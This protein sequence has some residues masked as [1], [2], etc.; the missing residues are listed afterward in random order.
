MFVYLENAD[1]Q[2]FILVENVGRWVFTQQGPIGERAAFSSIEAED[3]AGA[4]ATA[5]LLVA[6]AGKGGFVCVDAGPAPR[7]LLVDGRNESFVWFQVK[8]TMLLEASGELSLLDQTAPRA[9]FTA[10]DDEVETLRADKISALQADGYH[11]TFFGLGPLTASA[12]PTKKKTKPRG[13]TLAPLPSALREAV[14]DDPD[15]AEH[16]AAIAD[17]VDEARPLVRHLVEA[18]RAGRPFDATA[19]EPAVATL[20]FGK[21]HPAIVY[22]MHNE[23]P[24]PPVWKATHVAACTLT[25]RGRRF[26]KKTYYDSEASHLGDIAA[27]PAFACLHA[28]DL[29]VDG[30]SGFEALRPLV[31]QLRSLR[32]EVRRYGFHWRTMPARFFASATRLQ[33]L[34][35]AIEN[36]RDTFP[37]DDSLAHLGHLV[38]QSPRPLPVIG[39]PLPGLRSLALD[40]RLCVTVAD[41][42]ATL[43]QIATSAPNVTWLMATVGAGWLESSQTHLFLAGLERSALL[44]QLRQLSLPSGEQVTQ[45]APAQLATWRGGA[46]G[47]LASLELSHRYARHTGAVS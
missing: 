7:V 27:A 8:D 31:Q 44:T 29:R 22:T 2:R 39:T 19:L 40:L 26:E 32:L 30:T 24:P 17:F 20:L 47:H 34:T 35:L 13:P 25:T 15:N 16:W 28:L 41:F 36:E 6:H 12:R 21:H 42:T 5:Q 37:D 45:L 11:V 46:F 43:D 4:R 33:S 18:E 3:A 1:E 14:L 9:T 10:S 23:S 38:L